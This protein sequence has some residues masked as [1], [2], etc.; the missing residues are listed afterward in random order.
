MLKNIFCLYF[1]PIAKLIF[2][3]VLQD[4]NTQKTFYGFITP[5]KF[6]VEGKYDI[7]LFA[8]MY[9]LKEKP[10]QSYISCYRGIRTT[11]YS[12]DV[13]IWFSKERILKFHFSYHIWHFMCYVGLTSTQDHWLFNWK[14]Y[15]ISLPFLFSNT[16][17]SGN[18]NSWRSYYENIFWLLS[19]VS[20]ACELFSAN[21]IVFAFNDLAINDFIKSFIQE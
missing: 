19:Y 7:F 4:F 21:L 16:I 18:I 9:L 20:C 14:R 8:F 13:D 6:I 12:W 11:S 2:L 10:N 15:V 17:Y 5:S 1:S 3:K